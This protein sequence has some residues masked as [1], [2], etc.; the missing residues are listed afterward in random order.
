MKGVED[1]GRSLQLMSPEEQQAR[2]RM[3]EDTLAAV[4]WLR[5]R[6][7][8][9]DRATLE[10]R[11]RL[12]ASTEA[13]ERDRLERELMVGLWTRGTAL[14]RANELLLELAPERRDMLEIQIANARA[15]Q[16]VARQRLWGDASQN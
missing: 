6:V 4:A 16:Q 1:A 5:E 11:Q 12:D 7:E 8:H 3:P 9:V 10:T 2:R 14:E 15:E 13:A